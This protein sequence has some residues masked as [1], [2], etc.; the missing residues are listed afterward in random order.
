ML[1][2]RLLTLRFGRAKL[3]NEMDFNG[4]GLISTD[5]LYKWISRRAGVDL[6]E[7]LSAGK[8]TEISGL[9]AFLSSIMEVMSNH[10]VYVRH[11]VVTLT[12]LGRSVRFVM[13]QAR[14][15]LILLPCLPGHYQH[16]RNVYLTTP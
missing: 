16:L 1:A 15:S 4:D 11:L 14:L 5:E 13:E 10:N 9:G 8:A 12:M 6:W 7:I 3:F 2:A